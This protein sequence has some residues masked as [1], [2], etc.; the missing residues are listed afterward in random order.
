MYARTLIAQQNIADAEDQGLV[1]ASHGCIRIYLSKTGNKK[2]PVR[3]F[4]QIESG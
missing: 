4:A 3:C 2:N 1:T